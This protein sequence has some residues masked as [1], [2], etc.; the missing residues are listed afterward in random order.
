[1]PSVPLVLNY[2]EISVIVNTKESE[3]ATHDSENGIF[4]KAFR[5][6][7]LGP[8]AV[9]LI[10]RRPPRPAHFASNVAMNYDRCSM[11]GIPTNQSSP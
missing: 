11:C 4:F 5:A 2:A 8:D 7:M 9:G 3:H 10:R 6:A 1:M